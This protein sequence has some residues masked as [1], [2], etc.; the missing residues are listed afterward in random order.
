MLKLCT[1]LCSKCFIHTLVDLVI[2][3]YRYLI[4]NI[5]PYNKLYIRNKYMLYLSTHYTVICDDKVVS[6][7]VSYSRGPY[8]RG[9]C[10]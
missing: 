2:L 8:F 10:S 5:I 4:S 6:N 3:Y 9:L 1:S 7:D